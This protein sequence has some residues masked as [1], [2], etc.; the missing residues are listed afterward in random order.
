LAQEAEVPH[1]STGD[2]FREALKRETELGKQAKKYMEAG[3]LVPDEI[4]VGIVRERL[5]EDDCRHG[6]ILDGFPRTISQAEALES[7]LDEMGVALDAVIG[8]DVPEDVVVKRLTGRRVCRECGATFHV[9]FNPPKREGVCDRCGNTLI[10]RDDDRED[11]VR[12]RLRVHL[13]ETACLAR[14][15]R[16][17]SLLRRVH[18]GGAIAEVTRRIREVLKG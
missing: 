4:V 17:K 14:Y 18:G 3:R 1:V 5:A 13:K 10:Q 9:D 6:F 11:T 8:L 2:I 15:Y 12:K 7:M 16:E